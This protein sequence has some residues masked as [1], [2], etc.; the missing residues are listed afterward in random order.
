MNKLL[1]FLLSG[2]GKII[3]KMGAAKGHDLK[4]QLNR[5]KR[6]PILKGPSGNLQALMVRH[7]KDLLLK[8]SN[9]G[10]GEP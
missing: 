4:P 6:S 7:P 3:H 2:K 10:G 5:T 1:R 9:Q 8:R